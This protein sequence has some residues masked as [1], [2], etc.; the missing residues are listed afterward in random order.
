LQPSVLSQ[1]RTIQSRYFASPV[2]AHA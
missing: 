2:T 1:L